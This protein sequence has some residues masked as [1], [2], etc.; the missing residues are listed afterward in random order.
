[1][2]IGRLRLCSAMQARVLQ[3][4]VTL[5]VFVMLNLYVMNVN[6]LYVL[7]AGVFLQ[8]LEPVS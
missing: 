7:I 1:M 4:S 2:Q 6:A 5:V 3:K 8:V